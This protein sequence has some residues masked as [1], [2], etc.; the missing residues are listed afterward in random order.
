MFIY[1]TDSVEDDIFQGLSILYT[2]LVMEGAYKIAM[3]SCYYKLETQY[4][5]GGELFI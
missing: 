4:F 2:K 5:V 3:H 1:S